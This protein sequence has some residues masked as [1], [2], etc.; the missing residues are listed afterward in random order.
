MTSFVLLRYLA[1]AC[2]LAGCVT[3]AE[4]KDDEY[5]KVDP[6]LAQVI[7]AMPE[8]LVEAP[9]RIPWRLFV[10]AGAK[11][12]GEGRFP[13]VFFLHGAGMRGADN[14]GPMF[15]AHPF[16]QAENQGR[17][18]CFILAPQCPNGRMWSPIPWFGEGKARIRDNYPAEPE[19][20]A[21]LAAAFKVLDQTLAAWPVDAKRIYVV[22]MSMGGYGTWD[23]LLRRPQTWAAAVPICGGGDPAKV[24]LYKDVPIWAWHGAND[25]VVPAKTSRGMIE[26]LTAA[27][28]TPKY[29]ELPKVNH[30]SWGPAFEDPEFH[31]WL[32]AQRR[33]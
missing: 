30:G 3:A 12:G 24:A 13:L 23:A 29:S 11:P 21:E 5:G 1:T 31:A 14:V 32:F 22:G 10:P 4:K 9:A 27:G 33:P 2:L 16:W 28:G 6:A 8:G 15:L 20:K 18:P 25:A 7:A 26:A 19:A 17:N